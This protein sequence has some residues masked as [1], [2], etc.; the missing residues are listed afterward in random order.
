MGMYD[1]LARKD[2]IRI[3]FRYFRGLLHNKTRVRELSRGVVYVILYVYPFRYNS[4]M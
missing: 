2:V 3:D 1:I 4:D